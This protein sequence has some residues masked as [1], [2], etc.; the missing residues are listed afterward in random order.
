MMMMMMMM[1]CCF[2]TLVRSNKRLVMLHHYLS[3]MALWTWS[4]SFRPPDSDLDA[5]FNDGL[6]FDMVAVVMGACK[7]LADTVR[8]K[9][10][11]ERNNDEKEWIS[12]DRVMFPDKY[13]DISGELLLRMTTSSVTVTVMSACSCC[14]ANAL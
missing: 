4:V 14:V 7:S 1:C 10:A 8:A 13:M 6:L 5:D 3:R 2:I 11:L 12:V 9:S